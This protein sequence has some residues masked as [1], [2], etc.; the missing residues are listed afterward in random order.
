MIATTRVRHH[1]L[2]AVG[3]PQGVEG[4]SER[5]QKDG[6]DE[7][8][9]AQAN[10]E[11]ASTEDWTRVSPLM[12]VKKSATVFART[13]CLVSWRGFEGST[14]MFV[15]RCRKLPR[16]AGGSRL[17]EPGDAPASGS[18]RVDSPWRRPRRP[19]RERNRPLGTESRGFCRE[20]QLR[21]AGTSPHRLASSD[22]PHCPTR[23]DTRRMRCCAQ[24]GAGHPHRSRL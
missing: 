3:E 15:R 18:S 22:C 1:A 2:A 16:A 24:R 17:L 20:P 6:A 8:G 11:R 19:A 13:M 12:S 10:G 23:G 5:K 7:G 14:P 4:Q 21:H 9:A